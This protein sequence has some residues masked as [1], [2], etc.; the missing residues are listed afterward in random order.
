MCM[1]VHVHAHTQ[2]P[3]PRPDPCPRPCPLLL[4]QG[5]ETT[6]GVFNNSL[7]DQIRPQGSVP[8]WARVTAANRLAS[9]AEA[10]HTAF[11]E[12][13]SGTYNNQWMTVHCKRFT[14]PPDPN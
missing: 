7:Y 14:T 13:N 9:S 11:Y 2:C 8:Y 10:W 5:I 4:P 6:N 1:H 12:Y 3:C